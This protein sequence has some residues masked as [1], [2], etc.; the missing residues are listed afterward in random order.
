M[1]ISMKCLD[2]GKNVFATNEAYRKLGAQLTLT[3]RLFFSR[4]SGLWRGDCFLGIQ[5]DPICQFRDWRK[6]QPGRRTAPLCG[7]NR[8]VPVR[9]SIRREPQGGNPG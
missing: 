3:V 5:C 6:N 4:S 8:M 7:D 1:S 2:E 9:A